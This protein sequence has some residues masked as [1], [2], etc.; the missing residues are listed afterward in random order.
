MNKTIVLLAVVIIIAVLIT[1]FFISGIGTDI[2]ILGVNPL[3]GQTEC[4]DGK[5]NDDDKFVDLTDP[6]CKSKDDKTELDSTRE[7]DDGIDNDNDGYIDMKDPGCVSPIDVDESNCGDNVCE[8]LE[9]CS[10][11]PEDCGLCL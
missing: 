11:C 4:N 1:S 3:K 8:G 10:S 9:T 2:V 7:C 6:G 5:D